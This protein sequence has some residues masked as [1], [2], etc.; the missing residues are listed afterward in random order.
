MSP[1]SGSA[2]QWF[3]KHSHTKFSGWAKSGLLFPSSKVNKLW[4]FCHFPLNVV[5]TLFSTLLSPPPRINWQLQFTSASSASSYPLLLFFP[6]W[7]FTSRMHH[8]IIQCSLSNATAC[9]LK[10]VLVRCESTAPGYNSFSHMN[11]MRKRIRGP[12]PV[13]KCEWVADLTVIHE[14]QTSWQIEM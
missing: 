5:V 3:Q 11:P 8:R 14:L 7:P 12:A 10:C 13:S 4:R 6:L 9:F 2:S 1:S